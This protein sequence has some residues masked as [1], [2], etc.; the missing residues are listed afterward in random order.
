VTQASGAHFNVATASA[1]GTVYDGDELSTEAD[2]ALQFRG[3]AALIYLS[4]ASGVILRSLANGTQAQLRNGIAVFSTVRAS[5]LEI[6]AD[7]AAIRPLA[8]V[9]TTAQITVIGPK[10]ILIYARRG[11][12]QFSYRA[13]SAILQEDFSYR[14][15]L[16]PEAASTAQETQ[17]G[18]APSIR[19]S[20]SF[21]I[22]VGA[23]IALITAIALHHYL[24]IESPDH[25]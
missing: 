11:A 10:E 21:K 14:I 3:N 9:S 7:H 8:D 13:D 5:A 23:G 6:L 2:G 24:A 12:L 15:L 1:G 17:K 25:P 20:K 19:K 18:P 16:D 22:I 4:G